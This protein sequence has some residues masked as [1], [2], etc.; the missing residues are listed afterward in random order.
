MKPAS[1][2]FVATGCVILAV[3]IAA[4]HSDPSRGYSFASTFPEGVNSISVNVFENQTFAVGLERDVTE[5]VIKELQRSTPLLV[6]RAGSA[7]SDLVGIITSA[8]MQ[9]LSLD[10]QTGLAQELAVQ[11]TVDFDWRDRR[12]GKLL[13]SRRNFTATDTFVPARQTGERLEVGQTSAAQRLAKELVAD[14]RADW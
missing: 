1:L 12:S 10:S 14:L 6:V 9:R 2:L 11:I 4:C 7:D 5:A 8:E 13:S 3:G